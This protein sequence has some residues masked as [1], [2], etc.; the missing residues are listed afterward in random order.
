MFTNIRTTAADKSREHIKKIES[1]VQAEKFVELRS[2][3][4]RNVIFIS[5]GKFFFILLDD[6]WAA[7]KKSLMNSIKMFAMSNEISD[8]KL[9]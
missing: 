4:N 7:K 2:L 5:L 6:I 9:S 1:K 8:G 3:F